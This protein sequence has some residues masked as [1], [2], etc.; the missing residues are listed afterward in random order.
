MR[1]YALLMV[2]ALVFARAGQAAGAGIAT[3]S[4]QAARSAVLNDGR[5]STDIIAEV[6]DSSGA[7]LPDGTTVTFSTD[8]GTFAQ[9]GPTASAQTRAGT[10]RVRLTSQRKGTATIT[11]TVAGG[12]FQKCEV[13]F[14]DDASE[15]VAGNAFISIQSPGTL[16]YC[17]GERIIEANKRGSTD[18]GLRGFQATLAF[19]NIEISADSL[20]LDCTTNIVRANG[21]IVLKR[22]Q[23]SLKCGRLYYEVLTGKGYA[24][25]EVDNRLR[26]V[27]IKGGDLATEVQEKGILPSVFEFADL[28]EAKLVV[29][30]RQILL[31]PGEKLQFKRPRFY[32]DGQHIFSMAFYTLSLYSTEL[33]SDQLLKV[34]STGLGLDVPLYYD[35]SPNTTGVFRVRYG[36]QIGRNNLATRPGLSLDLVQSYGSTGTTGRYT[37]EFGLTGINRGDWGFRWSHSHDF[38]GD[39][40]LS[41]Y[42][43]LPKHQGIYGTTNLSKRFGNVLMGMTLSANRS[44]SGSPFS[45]SSAETYVETIPKRI[46]R[47]GYSIAYGGTINTSTSAAGIYRSQGTT[48]GVQTRLFSDPFRLDKN[49]T[50]TNYITLGHLWGTQGAAGATMLSSLAMQHSFGR[51]SSLQ[52]SYDFTQ[53]PG[54]I[55]GGGHH[56]FSFSFGSNGGSKWN[57]IAQ[58]S[59]MLDSGV[60]S[61]LADTTYNFA[62]RW[63]INLLA[64]IQ[65]FPAG[66]YRDYQFGLSRSIGGR[67]LQFW[68]STYS[69]RVFFDLEASRF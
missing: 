1:R 43:D 52:V 22:G 15:T 3:I 20:Q 31:F 2:L 49:T 47:T 30:A 59:R 17:A 62:R 11:A 13:V 12:G 34:G 4:L 9:G 40:R 8:L 61:L 29:S 14:T 63:R 24:T 58:A 25:A 48:E 10:A 46:G 23:K 33:F 57:I 55:T 32:Q 67:E 16:V 50:L 21:A 53:Q 56:R 42:I 60:T 54:Y 65:S 36:D 28:S 27:S 5:D 38:G 39:T 37:G 7:Y 45:G 69:H 6:R 64:T 18:D 68:Y 19:R 51:S 41:A 35:M 44:L 66:S 26:P